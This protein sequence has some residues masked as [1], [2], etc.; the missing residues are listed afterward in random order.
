MWIHQSDYRP[1]EL[2]ESLPSLTVK[3]HPLECTNSVLL[4]TSDSRDTKQCFQCFQAIP[5]PL[6]VLKDLL[7]SACHL[8]QHTVFLEMY[9]TSCMVSMS[10]KCFHIAS[11][12]LTLFLCCGIVFCR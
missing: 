8:Q 7:Y 1:A 11:W 3:I 5:I 10:H 6:H 4:L 2:A 12:L 9:K